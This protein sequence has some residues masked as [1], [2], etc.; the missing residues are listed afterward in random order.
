MHITSR[1]RPKKPFW[2]TC[3]AAIDVYSVTSSQIYTNLVFIHTRGPA[4]Q[5]SSERKPIEHE[6]NN[7]EHIPFAPWLAPFEPAASQ[8]A[9]HRNA[10]ASRRRTSRRS[11]ARRRWCAR[12]A[13][14]EVG[15]PSARRLGGPGSNR[16]REWLDECK[17]R[18]RC[19]DLLFEVSASLR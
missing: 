19:Q 11:K 5:I 7:I 17:A 13:G 6:S 14:A 3:A 15:P 1:T 8:I 10:D 16:K 18:G 9:T 12:P 2:A 4:Q